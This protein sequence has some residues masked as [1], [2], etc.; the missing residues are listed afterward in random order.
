MK[1]QSQYTTMKN[2][3]IPSPKEEQKIMKREW[4]D[5]SLMIEISRMP[6]LRLQLQGMVQE[7]IRQQQADQSQEGGKPQLTEGEG[8]AG[9]KKEE[10]LPASAPKVPQQ[11]PQSQEGAVSQRGF[12]GR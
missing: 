6:Q 9:R 8:G 1:I 11:A 3:G 4:E 5:P 2:V 12:R 10:S 7:E